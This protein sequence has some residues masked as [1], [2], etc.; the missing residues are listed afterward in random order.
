MT[1][2]LH[3]VIKSDVLENIV[4]VPQGRIIGPI[5]FIV[6][7][8]DILKILERMNENCCRLTKYA[9][10]TNLLIKKKYFPDLLIRSNKRIE[11][12]TKLVKKRLY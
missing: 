6:G 10:D 7:I 3:I 4:G 9:D 12:S 1:E 2:K 11:K 5:L 8:H